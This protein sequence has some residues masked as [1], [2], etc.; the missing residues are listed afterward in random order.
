MLSKII[1]THNS[2]FLRVSHPGTENAKKNYCVLKSSRFFLLCN[3][4]KAKLEHER[5]SRQLGFWQA[6]F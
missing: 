6:L 5:K 2:E 4:M 3:S 1:I